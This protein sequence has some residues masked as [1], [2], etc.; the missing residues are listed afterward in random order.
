MSQ[1]LSASINVDGRIELRGSYNA[2]L[3]EFF[4]SLPAARWNKIRL[5]WVCDLT[6]ATC[7]RIVS[8]A[9]A[10]A[11]IEADQII[12]ETGQEFFRASIARASHEQPPVR[13]TDAWRHQCEAYSFAAQRRG[14]LLWVAMGG[15]KSKITVDLIQNRAD[16]Q[17]TLILCPVSVRGVWRREFAKH[18]AVA[19]NLLVL[20]DGTMKRKADLTR[21]HLQLCQA[22]GERAVV[23]V[24]YES[25]WR[26]EL[27]KELLRWRW[28]FVV[29]DES[30]RI[31]GHNAKQS[32]AAAAFGAN[33]DYRLALTGTPLANAPTDAFGQLRFVDPGI[34]GTSYFRFRARYTIPG[35][36]GAEHI[37]GYKNQE[38]L[39]SKMDLVTFHVGNEVLDLP[40]VTHES[41]E[42]KLDQ[43][44]RRVA[45]ELADDL[46]A[47][48]DDGGEV[49]AANGL[50]KLLRLAQVSGGHV[51]GDDDLVRHVGQSKQSTFDDLLEDIHEPV[52]VFCRFREDLNRVRAV[53]EKYR[54]TYGEISG[55]RKDLTPHA[56]MPEWVDVMGV[57]HAAGGVGVDL[58]A[59]RI[60]IYWNHP[61][62]L[63]DY[64]QTLARIHRPGQT[65]PVLYYHL[66][67]EQSVD[68]TVLKALEKK[69]DV[70]ES[71]LS[72]LKGVDDES[73]VG[74]VR[75]PEPSIA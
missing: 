53:A 57:Q 13:L 65:R 25:A 69:S 29:C 44:E 51:K 70:V 58:T 8:E 21:N 2:A 73:I 43:T 52:V 61:W 5:C 64:E 14:S 35:P 39:A 63:G 40:P 67:A 68:S 37:V 34:F 1:L 41:I 7:W 56:T 30:A 6:P 16:N 17:R 50:V 23:V 19:F 27:A 11:H 59:A 3:M 74:G 26:D 60:G 62:S 46:I 75:E 36:F 71:I 54:R 33:A 10:H 47:F 55:A 42:F 24:N 28:S 49:T 20:E 48:L 15:G 9:A 45:D 72:H 66:V 31:K 32:R 38:E 18:A 4:H 22:R 12:R